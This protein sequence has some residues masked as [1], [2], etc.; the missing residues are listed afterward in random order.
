MQAP[1]ATSVIVAP[2]APPDLQ[3]VP[4]VVEKLT[5]RPDDAVAATV[6]GD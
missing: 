4:V 3:T 5:V 6:I 2:F 1:A